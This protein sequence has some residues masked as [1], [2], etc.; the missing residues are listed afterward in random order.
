MQ[1]YDVIV[2]GAGG[3]GSAALFQLASRGLRVLGIDRFSPPHDRGSSHGQSRIIRLAYFEHPDYVPLLREAYRGWT[4]LEADAQAELYV[5]TG[6]VE[7]GPRD[8]IVVP[9][10]LRAAEEHGLNVQQLAPQEISQRWPLLNVPD[11]L[12]GVF[13]EEAG[14]LRVENCIAAYQDAAINRG[15]D[16]AT[17]CEVLTWDCDA[18]VRL[19]TTRG[20]Y[21]ADRLVITAGPWSK[22]LLSDLALDL[23]IRRKAMFW[24]PTPAGRK[25]PPCY[26]FELPDQIYYGFPTTD[27]AT[28]KVAEHSGGRVIEG[29]G[30]DLEFDPLEQQRVTEFVA[31]F[32]PN[33][34][35]ECVN[36]SNCY[37]TMSPD[38]HFIVDRHPAHAQVTFAAGLSGHGFKF[39]PVIGEAL[40]DIVVDGGTDL[41][42]NFLRLDRLRTG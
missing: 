14:F 1:K 41:Q 33:V 20:V 16:M 37:Y 35:R 13:E 10:V 40:A 27:G 24:F 18:D 32:L 19:K 34:S 11:H 26:L 6:L 39:A 36:R 7:I 17:D 21:A 30:D 42:I 29:P 3:M 28:L 2:L 38:D 9:G 12:T 31:E 23:E 25:Q 4:E 22:Q 8:G 15:A 5:R